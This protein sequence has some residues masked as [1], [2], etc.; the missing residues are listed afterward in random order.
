LRSATTNIHISKVIYAP[1]RFVY[2]WCTDYREDDYKMVTGSKSRRLI[3]EKTKSRVVYITQPK[4]A[5]AA[6][7]VSIITL[8]PPQNWYADSISAKRNWTGEYHL[9]KLGPES[10]K[11]D[12]TSKSKWKIVPS[13][14]RIDLL[15]HYEEVW[16][17]FAAAL[18]RD[19][20]K[21]SDGKSCAFESKLK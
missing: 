17:Q 6:T 12:I 15:Q 13:P 3:V 21:K 9:R 14:T 11:L 4:G 20:K 1:L 2:D 8:H 5:K 7:A 10:T 19:F 18:E 16:N